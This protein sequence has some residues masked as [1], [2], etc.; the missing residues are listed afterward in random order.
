MPRHARSRPR[1]LPVPTKNSIALVW[2][3]ITASGLANECL[4]PQEVEP[5]DIGPIRHRPMVG[6]LHHRYYREAA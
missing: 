2:L 6:G 3:A 4:I 1:I 5:P